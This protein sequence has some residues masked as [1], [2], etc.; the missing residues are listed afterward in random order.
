MNGR[1]GLRGFRP[2]LAGNLVPGPGADAV[3]DE[4]VEVGRALGD[5]VPETSEA[6]ESAGLQNSMRGRMSSR[7]LPRSGTSF[8]SSWICP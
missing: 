7:T 4:E 2:P 5:R 6:R 1:C 8:T 3:V